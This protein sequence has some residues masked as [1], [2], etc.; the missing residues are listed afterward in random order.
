MRRIAA[1]FVALP[2][3]IAGGTAAHWLAYMLAV[4]ELGARRAL[5]VSEHAYQEGLPMVIGLLGGL[6][7]VLV[8]ALVLRGGSLVE[9]LR[10]HPAV[11]MAL[12]MG[13]FATQEFAERL[14]V[15]YGSPWNVWLEPTS[16]RGLAL[17]VPFG[18]LAFLAATLLLKAAVVVERVVRRRRPRAPRPTL[19]VSPLRLPAFTLAALP[20][21]IR[22]GD[23]LR[24]RGP[25]LAAPPSR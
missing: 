9:R 13:G 10:L 8:A 14:L 21:L 6:S 18:L 16:W 1:L 20:R 24:F 7:L 12:P 25:P 17:Q 19:A 3:M 5:L 4:P 11:F 15:G 23:A 2:I 22:A